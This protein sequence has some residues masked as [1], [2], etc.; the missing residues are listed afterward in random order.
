[1]SGSLPNEWG[2]LKLMQITDG[3]DVWLIMEELFNDMS[4]FLCNKGFI[5]DAFRKGTL[6]GLRVC[7]TDEMYHS[8]T[9]YLPFMA[10]PNNCGDAHTMYML[11]CFCIVQDT[12]PET[13][14]IIWTHSRARRLG[15]ATKMI[16][17]L[18]I[19]RADTPLPES[20]DF[21]TAVGIVA[22]DIK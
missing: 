5:L 14:D 18:G 6:F 19:K 7:E 3:T 10:R 21:W 20:K 11:P 16:E 1:M 8:K 13:V 4:G 9:R 15:F 12:N 2:E 22:N 17:L